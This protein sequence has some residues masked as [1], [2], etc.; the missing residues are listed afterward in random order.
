MFARGFKTWCENVAVSIRVELD[1]RKSDPLPAHRVSEH[2]GV[3]LVE[4]RDIVGLSKA[5]VSILFREDDWSAVTVG[6]P[7]KALLVRN[8]SHSS[9]RTSSD[10]MHELSHL[11]I[12]HEPSRIVFSQGMEIA[13]RSY[14]GG[15]EEEATWLAG[16]LLLPRYALLAIAKSGT[17]DEDACTR[18]GVSRHLLAYRKNVTGVARQIALRKA[19]GKGL[20][21]A[22]P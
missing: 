3:R 4:P 14:D 21:A 7:G 19:R 1:L 9:G 22:L 18:Y 10:I 8:P 5:D 12:G 15:Q 16:C 11:V 17:P 20:P 6:S 2:L 13:L